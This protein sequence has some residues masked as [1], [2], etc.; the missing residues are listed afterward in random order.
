MIFVQLVLFPKSWR[1]FNTGRER[2]KQN[3]LKIY[4]LEEDLWFDFA[5]FWP[6]DIY[7]DI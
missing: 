3:F 1:K 5:L 4:F 2:V 6:H 7:C